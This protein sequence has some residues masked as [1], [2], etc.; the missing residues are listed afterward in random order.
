MHRIIAFIILT[1]TFFGLAQCFHS[2]S[3]TQHNY[4]SA[5]TQTRT[6]LFISAQVSSNHQV[7]LEANQSQG[8]V[9]MNPGFMASPNSGRSFSAFVSPVWCTISSVSKSLNEENNLAALDKQILLYPNPTKDILNIQTPYTDWSYR[10]ISIEGK[11][12]FVS[13]EVNNPINQMNTSHLTKGIY[14][15]M[16]K[17]EEN[18]IEIL[19]FIKD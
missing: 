15:I 8:Y 1:N 7:V 17:N 11:E 9:L 16:I 12:I 4:A 14:L 18:Q 5:L 3:I 13:Q 6:S 10:I 19:K 2:H